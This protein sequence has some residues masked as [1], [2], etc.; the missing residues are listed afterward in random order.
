MSE[1]FHLT[2]PFQ[3]QPPF[4]AHQTIQCDIDGHLHRTNRAGSSNHAEQIHNG[5]EDADIYPGGYA[6]ENGEETFKE[7]SPNIESEY[8]LPS[9]KHPAVHG[10]SVSCLIFTW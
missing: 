5:G 2:G 9:E 7:Q 10:S 6:R 1:P 8:L 3:R 4:P